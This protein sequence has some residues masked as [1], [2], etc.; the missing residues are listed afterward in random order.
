M[1]QQVY[2]SICINPHHWVLSELWTDT[3]SLNMYNNFRSFGAVKLIDFLRFEDLIDHILLDIG[4]WNHV[5][6]PVQ[7]ATMVVTNVTDMP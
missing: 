6:L 3:L 5:D 7:K 4:Y 2:F 1:L